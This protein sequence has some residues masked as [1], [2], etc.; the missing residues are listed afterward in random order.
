ME[1]IFIKIDKNT[2]KKTTEEVI[3]IKNFNEELSVINKNIKEVEKEPDMITVSNDDK[4]FRL[5]KLEKRKKEIESY[6]NVK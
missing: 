6:I 5:E 2:I 1:T 3:D 4:F